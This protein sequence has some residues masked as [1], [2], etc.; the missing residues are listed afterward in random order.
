MT[1]R[2]TTPLLTEEQQQAQ[3]ADDAALDQRVTERTQQQA[4]PVTPPDPTASSLVTPQ[5][6]T[7]ARIPRARGAISPDSRQRIQ[8]AV[9]FHLGGKLPGVEWTAAVDP[10]SDL[11]IEMAGDNPALIAA[12]EADVNTL[13]ALT[14]RDIAERVMRGQPVS[15]FGDVFDAI[16]EVSWEIGATDLARRLETDKSDAISGMF[17]A[18][19]GEDAFTLGSEGPIRTD[20]E[21]P[22]R[23]TGV[24]SSAQFARGN[25]FQAIFREPGAWSFSPS[26]GV[27]AVTVGDQTIGV[28]VRP[29]FDPQTHLDVML[30]VVSAQADGRV[31]GGSLVATPGE[32]IISKITGAAHDV[33]GWLAEHPNVSQSI[34]T[35]YESFLISIGDPG[36][37]G[38]TVTGDTSGPLARGADEL[39]D[40]AGNVTEESVRLASMIPFP[41]WFAFLP[42]TRTR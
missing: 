26:S 22:A 39:A 14:D 19:T 17:E 30:E 32:G 10:I 41:F 35:L 8:A 16:A 7:S 33:G 25:A 9:A 36:A 38:R 2:P 23:F 3:Q 31:K 24:G 13:F 6:R 21:G 42:G 40:A 5:P 27:L 11:F 1:T 12:L 4:Q 15:Q 37:F 34:D 29:G 18:L 28:D 20:E